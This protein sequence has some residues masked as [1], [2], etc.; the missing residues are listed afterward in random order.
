MTDDIKIGKA[1]SEDLNDILVL[2]KLAFTSEAELYN[3]YNIEPLTQTIESLCTDYK[4]NVFLKA[5]RQD[6]II[7][8]VKIQNRD[9]CCWVG[10][11][12]VHPKHQGQGIGRKLMY[13]AEKTYPSA[14][15]FI[16]FTGAKSIKNIKLYESIGYIKQEEFYEK[17]NP[18]LMLIKMIKPIRN[19]N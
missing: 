18:N 1:S 11:L 9:N 13:E 5:E 15:C 10:K 6:K 16:L 2:Q 7:G 17:E 4:T 12:I 14:E 19:N 3:N 8:S